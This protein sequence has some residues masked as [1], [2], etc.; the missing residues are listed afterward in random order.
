MTLPTEIDGAHGEV[1]L[2]AWR[3][4]DGARLAWGR[5]ALEPG[6]YEV[7]GAPADFAFAR[8]GRIGRGALGASEPVLLRGE[9]GPLRLRRVGLAGEP[10]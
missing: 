3:D 5:L 9:P 6:D 1:S 8:H 7:L 4:V 10:R 2:E